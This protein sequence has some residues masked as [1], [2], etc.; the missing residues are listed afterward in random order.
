[1]RESDINK[2]ITDKVDEI[3]DRDSKQFIREIM[4]F[5]RSKMDREQPHYK[6]EYQDM[7]EQ[8]AL[9]EEE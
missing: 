1:M 3:E 9:T 5:E 4:A 7:I 6:D 8:Y 2:L